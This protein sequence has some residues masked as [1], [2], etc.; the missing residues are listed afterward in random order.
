M[1][2]ALAGDST[3]TDASGWGKAFTD[4]FN[5]DVTAIADLTTS[6]FKVVGADLYLHLKQ[7]RVKMR[8][9]AQ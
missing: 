1:K 2:I 3:V 7:K 8:Y 6:E 9:F 5:D 4:R